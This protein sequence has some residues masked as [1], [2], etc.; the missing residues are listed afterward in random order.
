[1]LTIN[2][3][4]MKDEV[5]VAQD[6]LEALEIRKETTAYPPREAGILVEPGISI[7]LDENRSRH[8]SARED[9]VWYD[10]FVMNGEG[11]TVARYIL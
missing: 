1:M 2:I 3:N 11:Q 9:G 10:I 6:T 4:T 5:V 8:F 7:Q